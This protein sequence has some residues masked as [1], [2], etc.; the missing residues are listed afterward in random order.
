MESLSA[1]ARQFLSM[2][3]KPD[4]DHI[5]GLSPA[6]SHRAE[7]DLPQSP[8]D[9]GTITE[10]YDYLRL[11]FAR[12]GEP[13][14]PTHGEPLERRPSARWWIRFFPCREGQRIMVLA[15]VIRDRK[16][17]HLHVFKELTAGASSA[18]G[19]TAWWWTST[20]RPELDKKKKHSIEAVIDRLR[21]KD[22]VQQRLAES[23]ET[24]LELADGIVAIQNM[25]DEKAD[26]LLFS[27]RFACPQCGYSLS[28]LEP[29][30][31]SFNNPAGACED[32]DG[33]G[34]KS[35][36]DPDLVVQDPTLNWPKAPSAAGTDGTCTTSTCC[37]RSPSTTVSTL[38]RPSTS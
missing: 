17:E 36:F 9:G 18:P 32:C 1:Y 37:H 25:D 22:D 34:V 14:C 19:S 38:K 4:V 10:I 16:C 7:I 27:A 20:L 15:P 33:L 13:R 26:P 8:L 12:V 29:R 35:Y 11:L 31:F 21:V 3:E 28:E 23:I 2:M 24:A 5:E 30:M 6:I